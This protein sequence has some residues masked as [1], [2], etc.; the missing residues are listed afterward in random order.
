L[1][2]V[3]VRTSVS[4][5]SSRIGRGGLRRYQDHMLR[6]TVWH[7]SLHSPFYRRKFASLGISPRAVRTQ[8]DLPKLGFFTTGRDLQANPFDFLAVPR[9][10]AVRIVTTS[11]TTGP[12]KV[13]FYTR[14]D[15]N[16]LIAKLH[17]GFVLVGTSPDDV[18]QIMFCA[19]TPTWVG[20][21]L[22]QAALE[23]L[24]CLVVPL[25]NAPSPQAQVEAIRTY[26][27]T[28]L[29][30][31]PSY[32]HRVTEEGKRLMDLRSLGVKRI[33]VGA[34]PNSREF[35]DYLE[36]VW[37]AK[38][39]EGYGLQEL[40]AGVA[41][42]C[43]HKEGMHL[44]LYVAVEVVDPLSGE[45]VPDGQPGEL[46]LTSLGRMATPLIRYRSG[47]LARL[48]PDEPCPCGMIPT[49]KIGHILGRTDDMI[50][51]G[52]GENLLPS[53][54]SRVMIQVPE[55][56]GWQMVV[57][58]EGYRDTV[59]LRVE[60]LRR[61]DDMVTQIVEALYRCVPFIRHDVFESQTIAPPVVEFLE[62][63][64]LQSASPVKIRPVVDM[65]R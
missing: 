65:R 56:E 52:T 51:L 36:E 21:T 14:R 37:G 60:T 63:G 3:L 20:G 10:Q 7:A 12:P 35:R 1:R 28:Y 19:G 50:F 45:P 2:E 17:V 34:E 13:T 44:D 59:C 39:F 58:K 48:L 9:R 8:A 49:R 38:A 18:G 16:Q 54:L 57:G 61:S 42:S 33:Y 15:W 40:G 4:G 5:I 32:L 43:P 27:S 22:I 23:R 11:G 25:G 47:D 29:F 31:T 26:G 62:P 6:R 55:V 46:V 64:T 30:G 24:G 41:G 53:E